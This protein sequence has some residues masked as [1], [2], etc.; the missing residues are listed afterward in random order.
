MSSAMKQ[1]LRSKVHNFLRGCQDL[2]TTNALFKQLV[3]QRSRGGLCIRLPIKTYEIVD[4]TT[5]RVKDVVATDGTEKDCVSFR[6]RASKILVDLSWNSG[7]DFDLVVKEPG[8]GELSRFNRESRTGRLN[9]DAND[10][11]CGIPLVSGRETARYL[12]STNSVKTGLYFVE[13]RHFKNCGRGGRKWKLQVSINGKMVQMKQ[14]R[15]NRDL[16]KIVARTRF[17]FF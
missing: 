11:G 14:G 4:R 15:S 17:R 3:Q 13:V 12:V 2:T 6:S 10:D 7:D 1:S 5:R 8:G 9:D 16:D